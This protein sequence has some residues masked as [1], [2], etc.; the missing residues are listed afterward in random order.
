MGILAEYSD[1]ELREELER[2][3][4]KAPKPLPNALENYDKLRNF[5]IADIDRQAL[6]RKESRDFEKRVCELALEAVFGPKYWDWRNKQK[7]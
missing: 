5:I 2:R 1:E 6:T 7:W 3:K 4:S